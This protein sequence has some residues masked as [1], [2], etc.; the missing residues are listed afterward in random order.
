MKIYEHIMALENRMR[1]FLFEGKHSDEYKK[2]KVGGKW[3]V[4]HK[5]YPLCYR[6][7]L[8]DGRIDDSGTLR[9]Y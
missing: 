7:F 4:T 8:E 9:M 1:E 6:F 5:T 3:L 2:E